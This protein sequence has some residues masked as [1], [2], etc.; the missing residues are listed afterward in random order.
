M[1][2][3]HFAAVVVVSGLVQL[4]NPL[5][6]ATA[7]RG[8]ALAAAETTAPRKH[9]EDLAA[10]FAQYYEPVRADAR[11]AVP[12]Y[13]LPLALAKVTN[14]AAVA[15]ALE[16][17]ADEPLLRR[18]GFLVMKP[19]R[20][21]WKREDIVAP[22][23]TLKVMGVPVFVT[24]DTLLHLY[25][26]QFDET[27]KDIEE[28]EFFDDVLSLSQLVASEAG[29]VYASSTG[30]RKEAARLAQAYGTVGLALLEGLGDAELASEAESLLK[31][32]SSWQ[33]ARRA[34]NAQRQ[35]LTKHRQTIQTIL[36]GQM[37]STYQWQEGAK[38]LKTA[39]SEFVKRHKAVGA[40]IP[41]AVAAD[42]RAELALIGAHKGFEPSPLFTYKEDYSQYVPRGHYTRSYKLR[43]YFLAMMWYGR[44]TFLLKGGQPY[45]PGSVP[46]LVSEETARK[47]TFAAAMI[48]RILD[49]E[50]LP[51]GRAARE[52]WERLYAV[53]AFYVGLADDLGLTEYAGAFR[54]VFG[55]AIQPEALAKKG[56][57]LRFQL[58]LAKFN[59]PAIYGGTGGQEVDSGAADPQALLK[60]L[61]KTMG[62]RLM[63]QRFV[64]DSYAMGRL[65]YPT[66]GKPNGKPDM[67]TAALGRGGY[68]RGFPRG[69]DVM[70]ILGSRRA[71]ELLT[72]L[73]DDDFGR[74]AEGENL[75][76]DVVFRAVKAEFD[77]LP[78]RDWNRNAYWSWLHAL[79]PLMADFGKGFPTFMTTKAW[80]DKC[81]AT[82]S[83][84][85]SQLRH[86]TILYAKQS[87]GMAAGAAPAKPKP[88]EGYVECV[89]ELYAR[90]LALTRMTRAGLADMKVT[91]KAAGERL[92]ALED[93][94]VRLLD[95]S[96]KELAN[97]ELSRDDYDFIRNFGA[98]L[99]YVS[100]PSAGRA[101]WQQR[102]ELNEAMKTTLIADVHTDQ[103]T[104]Q[105]LE[106]G[107]GYVDLIV[108]CYRQPDG[109]LVAG[110]G[111]VLSYYEFKHPM[112][113]RLTD[114]KWRQML[115][116]GKAPQRPKWLKSYVRP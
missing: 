82:A 62:F 57:M 71:R 73:R 16:L 99:K 84:S 90:L 39:L 88:V 51:D 65:V 50:K 61:D 4:A 83:A 93:I 70:A 66:V 68:V 91:T 53:T 49:A 30:E 21:F 89:P 109:R 19:P 11:P 98:K 102:E 105:V 96:Q 6:T 92:K 38:T 85:W 9:A 40:S 14:Y 104:R 23:K 42:V 75:R 112:S 95:I 54:N 7:G 24:A 64:P 41:K 8:E 33:I 78:E 27:L 17:G 44:M 72:E 46:F 80:R 100:I 56:A 110:A 37:Y 103:N 107:T 113:D 20:R 10:R 18:N 77:A 55:A 31:T 2:T 1:K 36:A 3:R 52:V 101:N 111:P 81:V 106:E 76:Y 79:K 48:T 69:L 116:G 32:V 26:V 115:Q 67:F 29:D 34:T 86:D 45:G 47:Q 13:T 63:G 5:G 60:A 22:Y 108:V 43:K 87:Y 97:R 94:L 59:P 15:K 114:P 12:P 28:R 74:N 58:E 35:V 25:H